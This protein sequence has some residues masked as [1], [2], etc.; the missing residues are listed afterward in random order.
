MA[1][2]SKRG[3]RWRVRYIGP[4]GKQKSISC[5]TKIE[6]EKRAREAERSV[7]RGEWRDPRRGAVTVSEWSEQWLRTRVDLRPTTRAR[8]ESIVRLH[9]QKRFGDRKLS[10]LSNYDVRA[11][12]SEMVDAGV[13]TTTIRKS[14]FALRK[15]L[16]AAIADRRISVNAAA[17]VD[18]PAE[19]QADQMFLTR[20]EVDILADVILPRYRAMILLAAYGGLRWGELVALRR[21]RID[22]L[23]SRVTVSE[24]AIQVGGK[25]EFGPP[26]TKKSKRVVPVARQVM[27]EVEQ[28]LASHVAP[29]ADALVFTS[30]EGGPL[31]R[32]SFAREAWRP[33]TKAADQVGLRFHDLRHTFVAVMVAAGANPKEVS[34]WAGHSTVAFTLDR[35]GH[36]YDDHG[37]DVIDRI[38]AML[39]TTRPTNASIRS[40]G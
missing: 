19:Q 13:G 30:A 37:D 40:I 20:D 11:W 22:T 8:M 16:D 35:Y 1:T 27:R 32:A 12:V 18:V 23:R 3:T 34:T 39:A 6:A 4:D 36:L 17:V 15:M 21:D 7:D 26:K 14:V 9:V 28:H 5:A 31:W 2:I 10:S 24:T 29:E 38:D 25:I 33:A